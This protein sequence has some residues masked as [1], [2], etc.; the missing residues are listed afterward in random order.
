MKRAI[1]LLMLVSL[2]GCA[3]PSWAAPPERRAPL[4]SGV[5]LVRFNLS[6]AATLPAGSTIL[7]KGELVPAANQF[8]GGASRFRPT[9]LAS[10]TSR[11][12]LRGSL[13]HDFFTRLHWVSRPPHG[14]APDRRQ[15]D[16][17]Q[18]LEGDRRARQRGLL[19]E[20]S[21]EDRINEEVRVILDAYSD[22]MRKSGAQYAEM[23]KKVKN[24]LSKK[25]KA[26]L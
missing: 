20:L 23:F 1:C 11:T 7:C 22:E 26:V 14:Q 4:D 13:A 16:H 17:H 18:R 15:N 9:P 2:L 10:A 24:E 6:V 19:D 25:Y 8:N 12:V 5:S 3:S 21:L